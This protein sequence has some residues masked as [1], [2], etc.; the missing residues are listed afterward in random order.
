MSRHDNPIQLAEGQS[1]GM[2]THVPVLGVLMMV[3]GGLMILLGIYY[4]G[5]ALVFPEAL[6]AQFKQNPAFQ[7]NP[8]F[9]PQQLESLAM[10][11]CIGFGVVSTVLG[12][13]TLYSGF[14][15]F[16]Y[17]G[18]TLGL[19]TLFGMFFTLCGC[20]CFPTGLALAIY[21]LIVLFNRPVAEAFVLGAK[22]YSGKEVQAAFNQQSV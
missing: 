19:V 16:R 17:R 10:S 5:F 8:Q 13:V 7:N 1:R 22:G 3:Q 20:Y 14:S 9:T 4:L 6:E 2:V 12:L 21:G 18:R 11:F 15:V